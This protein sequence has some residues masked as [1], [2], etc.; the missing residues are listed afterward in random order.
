MRTEIYFAGGCFWGT[1]HYF[2]QLEGVLETQA[3]Y[4]NGDIPS[5]TY[6]Q[7]YTD[8]TG[9]AECVKVTYNSEII[10]LE[11]L[12][13]MYFRS[14]DP[15]IMNRQ[16]NDCGTRYRTGIYWTKESDKEIV[17]KI[18]SEIES[19]YKTPLAVEKLP[20][21]NFYPAEEYHQEYLMKNP[22]G[23]CHLSFETLMMAKNYTSVINELRKYS[24]HQKK[25]V[26]Q[27][28][29]KTAPGEYGEG[30]KFLGVTNPNIR[31][32]AK[33]FSE[34]SWETL[35]ALI[36][37]QWHEVRLC[38]LFIA[39]IKYKKEPQKGLQF[40]LS[41]LKWVNNWDLVDLS[42]PNLL[43]QYLIE[44]KERQILTSLI[45]VNNLWYK[46][47][48]IVAT[49]PLIKKGEFE[50]TLTLA[51]KLLTTKEDL[52]QKAAGWMLREIG[53]K[54]NDTLLEFL[55]KN[56]SRMPGTMLRYSIEKLPESQRQEYL[57]RKKRDKL[58]KKNQTL[59]QI[60]KN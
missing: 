25:T 2:K 36:E 52:L 13:R 3:G 33:Q 1:E 19:L 55:D 4:A 26:L 42:A 16:G 40:Y 21:K 24:D 54:D 23:Y 56:V 43:G 35:E 46:R 18:Y 48:A 34:L 53:K 17:E 10:P 6:Q 15:L 57:T 22:Q 28:F 59:T 30:D 51:E 11:T 58:P 32:V 44:Q 49:L 39:I 8:T 47:I 37:S 41:H 31:K 29:F 27:R 50:T 5:P 7:V 20:L 38:T 45:E 9:F 12:C 60:V 14:I